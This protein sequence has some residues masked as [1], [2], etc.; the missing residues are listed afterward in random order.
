VQGEYV[1]ADTPEIVFYH[2]VSEEA[3]KA[4]IAKLK[5]HSARAFTD[6]VTYEPWHDIPSMYFFCETDKAIPLPIQQQM[7]QMLGAAVPTFTSD[8]SH[9]PFL[10]QPQKVVEGLEYAVK[11]SQSK[12]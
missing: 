6:E 11:V 9:S 7:A 2:D 10:S 5:H 4:A 8:A 1:H 12:K 3:Q